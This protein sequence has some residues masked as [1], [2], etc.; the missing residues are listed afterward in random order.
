MSW[1]ARS[2]NIF[3]ARTRHEQTWTH[4]IHHGPDLG[5]AT[6]FPFIIF[7]VPGHKANI[8]FVLG[9]SSWSIE[10]FEIEIFATLEVHN[11]VCRPLIKVTFVVKL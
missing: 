1:L 8:H 10:I 11:F 9:L 3:G 5:E 6:T 4:K 7:F 2:L